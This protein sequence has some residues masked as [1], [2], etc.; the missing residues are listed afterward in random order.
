METAL[1]NLPNFNDYLVKVK[2]PC[3]FDTM[4]NNAHYDDFIFFHTEHSLLRSKQREIPN[5]LIELAISFG[6]NIETPSSSYYIFSNKYLD[7]ITEGVKKKITNLVVIIS[8]NENV[9]ITCFYC[10]NP[11]KLIKKKAKH[12]INN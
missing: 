10:N 6:K 8:K 11:M 12:F 9:I 7:D 1:I 5:Y 3:E 4:E 2:T